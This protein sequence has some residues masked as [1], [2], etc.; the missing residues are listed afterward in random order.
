MKIEGQIKMA[1]D[2]AEKNDE[3]LMMAKRNMRETNADD[4][5]VFL[6]NVESFYRQRRDAFREIASTLEGVRRLR[7]MLDS[8][9]SDGCTNIMFDIDKIRE[10]MGWDLIQKNDTT[11]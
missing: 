3:K 1:Q 7:D 10:V 11:D 8:A 9:Q 6:H 4:R 5:I 2:E